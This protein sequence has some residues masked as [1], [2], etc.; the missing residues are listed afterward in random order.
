MADEMTQRVKALAMKPANLSLILR[1]HMGEG[2]IDSC[3]LFSGRYTHAVVCSH[4]YA[5][6]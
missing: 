6:M 5:Y 3:K 2:E 4:T 1:T